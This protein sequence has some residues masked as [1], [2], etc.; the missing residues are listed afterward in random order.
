MTSHPVL[1][2]RDRQMD[3][4]LQAASTSNGVVCFA[5]E[6]RQNDEIKRFYWVLSP[7]KGGLLSEKCWGEESGRKADDAIRRG[8][9]L[10]NT[11]HLSVPKCE[12]RM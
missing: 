4:I 8:R 7:F 5:Q 11:S 3:G 9:R 12:V 2:C 10:E 1:K 6:T